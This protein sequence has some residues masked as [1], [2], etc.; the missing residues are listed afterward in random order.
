[1]RRTSALILCLLPLL[2]G[3]LGMPDRVAPVQGFDVS[4]Y[5]GTW[6]EIARLDHVF[7]RGLSQ[8]TAEYTLRDDGGINVINRG[9]HEEKGEWKEAKGKAYFVEDKQTGHLKVSFFGPFYSSYVIFGLDKEAYQYAF[10]SGF[11]TDYVWLLARSPE[12]SDEL[13]QQFVEAAKARGFDT[14]ALIWNY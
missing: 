10:V 12:V 7:E 6:H 11:N 13:K 9:Y 2:W 4:Q 8:I 14:S 3:C 1:M 5:T